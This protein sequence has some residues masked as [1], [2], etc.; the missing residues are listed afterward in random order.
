MTIRLAIVVPLA[1]SL[2]ASDKLTPADRV[3][4]IR[5]LTA[6]YGTVK[7]SLP[8]SKK[9][10]PFFANGTWDKQKW[11][12]AGRE[13]GPAARTGDLVKITKVDIHSDNIELEINGGFKTGPK[14]HERVQVGMG[15][16]TAPVSQGSMATAG[17]I[18]ALH[19]DGKVPPIEVKEIKKLLA[20]V[21]DFEKR[22]ATENYLDSLPAPVQSAI[23]DKRAVEGMDKDQVLL[24]LGKP[25]H[26]QRETKDGVELEDW[27]Y[28]QPPGKIVFV[29]FNGNK[30]V[31][32]KEAYAAL[33]GS[34]AEPLPPR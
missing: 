14:W 24:S 33:G 16:R 25:R 12:D 22:S 5:G 31:K 19:F 26:K 34:T 10:L 21:L 27:I 30:V 28:G 20:P 18:V 9:P 23:K 3:E 15:T 13:N 8:R 4:I 17:T 6:E 11:A 1:F 32:V 2:N 29:T 7:M